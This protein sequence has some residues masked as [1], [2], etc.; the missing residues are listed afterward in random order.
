MARG[1]V[2]AWGVLAAALLVDPCVAVADVV[3][4]YRLYHPGYGDHLFTTSASETAAATLSGGYVSEGIAAYVLAA[5]AEGSAPLY[6]LYHSESGD[7]FYT[8]SASERDSAVASSGY[9]YEGVAAHVFETQADAS[10]ALYRLYSPKS[11]DHL[12]TTDAAEIGSAASSAGY[13]Y[14]GIAAYVFQTPPPTRPVP[15]RNGFRILVDVNQMDASEAAR[16]AVLAADGVW[17]ITQNSP[18]IPASAWPGALARLNAAHWTVA[19]DNPDSAYEFD[20]V[21]GYIGRPVD[22]A[23]C[24]M[25]PGVI[26]RTG[27]DGP[28]LDATYDTILTPAEIEAQA[29]THGGKIVILTRS[30]RSDDPRRHAADASLGHPAVSGIAFETNPDG[31]GSVMW[32]QK[33]NEGINH[34]LSLGKKCYVLLPPKKNSVDYLSDVQAAMSYFA[35]SGQLA[36]PDLHIVLAVY[37][38]AD[39]GVGFLDAAAGSGPRNTLLAAVNWLKSYRDGVA[40]GPAAEAANE[41]APWAAARPTTAGA[42]GERPADLAPREEGPDDPGRRGGIELEPRSASGTLA[43]RGAAYVGTPSDEASLAGAVEPGRFAW[44]LRAGLRDA[45]ALS[46]ARGGARLAASARLPSGEFCVDDPAWYSLHQV[47]AANT[48]LPAGPPYPAD[49]SGYDTEYRYGYR[50]QYDFTGGPRKDVIA[51]QLAL[52]DNRA[53]LQSYFSGPVGPGPNAQWRRD[54]RDNPY[55]NGLFPPEAPSA[56]PRRLKFW[57]PAGTVGFLLRFGLPARRADFAAI[58]L[59]RPPEESDLKQA[60]TAPPAD[61]GVVL[62]SRLLRGEIVTGVHDGGGWLVF[63]AATVDADTSRLMRDGAPG[64]DRGAWLYAYLSGSHGTLLMNTMIDKH[65]FRAEYRSLAFKN[66]GDPICE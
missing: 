24:Y 4:L 12:L 26:P 66:D 3:P 15:G 32:N 54:W 37:V 6:R 65:A 62:M 58:R 64:L 5:P 13:V 44:S 39:S 48:R 56:L 47:G 34:C 45:L 51:C 2:M 38:R 27:P 43:G 63:A 55:F 28:A 49:A 31:P 57:L 20:A 1:G 9:V 25:E 11:G 23:M 30:Y 8:S 36:N 17:A 22:A 33:F 35:G 10:I 16:D 59:G 52:A 29:A 14:E 53:C 46:S 42:A 40:P 50:A 21:A 7:H 18:G 19:E 61:Q 60:P 41:P